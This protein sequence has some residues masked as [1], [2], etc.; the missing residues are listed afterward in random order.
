MINLFFI[1]H[2]YSGVKTYAKELLNWLASR[3]EVLI[4]KVYLECKTFNEYTVVK[5]GNILNI[6]IP[7]A[8][9]RGN[10]SKKYSQRCIDLMSPLLLQKNNL[11]F[12]L[13]NN[14]QTIL[15]LEAR[16]R[17]KA[18]LIYTLHFLPNYFSLFSR[19]NIV[20]KDITIEGDEMDREIYQSADQIICVTKFGMEVLNQHYDIPLTKLCLIYN[21]VGNASANN[22]STNYISKENIKHQLGFPKDIKI[23]LFVGRLM[24]GKG[25]E[26][27]IKAFNSL[28]KVIPGI[29]IVLVGEGNLPP[30]MELVQDFGKISFTGKLPHNKVEMLY[31]IADIGVIPSEFEQC[32]Y[33]AL[34]MMQHGLPIVCS[35]APGLKELFINRESALL[36][37]LRKRSDGL[38]GLEITDYELID[39]ITQLLHKNSLAKKLARNAQTNWQNHYTSAHMGQAVLQ[40]YKQL[41]TEPTENERKQEE[42]I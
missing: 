7:K 36:A 17:F 21:G 13:N 26:K 9:H 25:V 23:I 15:G 20:L 18:K 6:H 16:K 30:I 40:A 29:H 38:L 1:I 31:R 14:T 32:S 41:Q 35:D 8:K 2:D 37:L 28:S 11:I 27:L 3:Q 39:A 33:V 10:N 4:H 5:K 34:E 22:I 24:P 12:H 42:I 19:E